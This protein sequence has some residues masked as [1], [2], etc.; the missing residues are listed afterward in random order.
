MSIRYFK[1]VSDLGDLFHDLTSVAWEFPDLAG[2]VRDL[3][4]AAIEAAVNLNTDGVSEV[5]TKFRAIYDAFTASY[6]GQKAQIEKVI[7]SLK[8]V[9]ETLKS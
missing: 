7:A 6:E 1:L 2:P 3:G 5:L 8:A 9:L 4:R